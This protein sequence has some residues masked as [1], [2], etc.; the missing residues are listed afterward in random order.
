M[1]GQKVRIFFSKRVEKSIGFFSV[2]PFLRRVVPFLKHFL[3]SREFRERATVQNNLRDKTSIRFEK[4]T[5]NFVVFSTFRQT[6]FRRFRIPGTGDRTKT[7]RGGKLV[8]PIFVNFFSSSSSF[9]PLFPVE[10]FLQRFEFR[11]PGDRAKYLT[12]V[13]FSIVR[14]EN[15]PRDFISPS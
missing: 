5:F 2:C 1:T 7:K 13:F 14:F 4:G 9:L 3:Q 12:L 8:P 10:H 11:E 15:F 6:F